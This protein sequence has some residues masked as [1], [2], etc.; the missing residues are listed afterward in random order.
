M[1][2]PRIV[3]S[4]RSVALIH[5]FNSSILNKIPWVISFST[6]LPNFPEKESPFLYWL[7]VQALRSNFCKK[8]LPT[9]KNAMQILK[10]NPF[11]ESSMDQKMEIVHY[12]YPDIYKHRSIE[13]KKK[14][15]LNILFIGNDFFLKGGDILLAVFNN[16]KKDFN[17][18][19]TV[20]SEIRSDEW[21]TKTTK[22]DEERAKKSLTNSSSVKWINGA[23][24]KDIIEKFF[25]NADIFVH[26]TWSDCFGHVLCE[27]MSSGLPIISTKIRAIPEIIQHNKNGFLINVPVDRVGALYTEK[28]QRS[29]RIYY[30]VAMEENRGLFKERLKHYLITLIE[31]EDLRQ[32][33]GHKSRELFERKFS[34][35]VRNE[36]LLR[37]YREILG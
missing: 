28:V 1:A 16:I 5:T 13:K 33:F 2:Y 26:P 36:K 29:N 30:K 24:H 21:F 37:I 14:E 35:P 32:K 6:C 19:L 17:L 4:T 10:D 15:V 9:S 11:F 34:Y 20:V 25:P 3:F 23:P 27:A 18:E 7:A 31:N 22:K 8:L 12:A